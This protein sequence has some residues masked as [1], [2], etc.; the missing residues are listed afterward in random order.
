MEINKTLFTEELNQECPMVYIACLFM[1][2]LFHLEKGELLF[3]GY[4]FRLE[5]WKRPGDLFYNNV[6]IVHTT[7][8]HT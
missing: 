6:N 5:K 1:T 3:N 8:L 4:H 7:E 2:G